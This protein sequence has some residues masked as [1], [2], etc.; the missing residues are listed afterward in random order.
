VLF[1]VQVVCTYGTRLRTSYQSCS[2]VPRHHLIVCSSLQI[3]GELSVESFL[4]ASVTVCPRVYLRAHHHV[5]NIRRSPTACLTMRPEAQRRCHCTPSALIPALIDRHN[6]IS[7]STVVTLVATSVMSQTPSTAAASSRFQA[8]FDAA[9]KSYQKQTKKDLLAHPLASRLQSCDSTSAI[10]AVLQEQIQDLDKSR[11][12][13]ERLTKWLT[14]IVNVLYAFSAAVSGGVALVSL[15][16]SANVN[17]GASS[18]LYSVGIFARERDLCW[19]RCPP[20][21]K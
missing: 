2:C 4:H 10:L 8:I 21:S 5:Y 9:V 19:C 7:S 20:F 17:L 11:S 3:P 13:D 18:D 14:P 12:G 1:A 6:L 16:M 15:D